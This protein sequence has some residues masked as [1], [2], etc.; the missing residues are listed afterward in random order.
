MMSSMNPPRKISLIEDDPSISTMY[1]MKL[2]ASGFEVGVAFDGQQGLEL[3]DKTRPDL[4]LLDLKMPVMS[5]SEML[6]KLRETEWG[7]D[8]LVIVLTNISR[9]EAPH[10]LRLLN[11]KKY[12]VKVHITPNQLVDVINNVLDAHPHRL[13]NEPV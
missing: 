3:I 1:K 13:H 7:R 10:E 9:D 8:I 11:V 6:K 5:G 12:I 2:E 4:I